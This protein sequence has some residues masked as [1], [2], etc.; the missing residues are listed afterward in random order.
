[1]VAGHTEVTAGALLVLPHVMPD[2]DLADGI[3]KGHAQG[4]AAGMPCYTVPNDPVQV[5]M[6][7][8]KGPMSCRRR[9]RP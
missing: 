9:G 6:G 5:F 7:A 4:F 2:E 8:L 1:M 3:G